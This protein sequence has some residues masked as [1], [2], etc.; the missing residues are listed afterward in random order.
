MIS[1]FADGRSACRQRAKRR[2]EGG[3]VAD[4]FN[5]GEQDSEASPDSERN[6][7]TGA[8]LLRRVSV[9]VEQIQDRGI[10]E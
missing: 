10:R 7:P 6:E 2:R 5:A 3:G 8:T 1:G 4:P 9:S